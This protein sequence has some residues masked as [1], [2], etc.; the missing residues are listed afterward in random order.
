MS[1]D[2]ARLVDEAPKDT[3]YGRSPF[4]RDRARVLHS[5]AFRRLAAK[6]Q[7]HTAGTND[8]LRTR[9]THSLE[10]AQI[11][12]EMGARLGCDPDVVDTAGLAHDLGHPP[13]GHNGEYALDELAAACGGFEGN[14]QTLR[15]LTRLEA[16]VFAPDGRSAGLN[17][18]R[19]ALDA[20]S[21]YPWPRRPGERKFGVYA[22]DR[23]VFD[24]LREGAPP[25]ARRCLEAQVMDWADDVAYSVH[26]VEDGIHGGYVDLRP[27]LA[28]AD[29]RR[30]LCADVAAEYSGEAPEDLGE[31]L[32]DL[33]ADPVLAPLAAYDGS[34]RA[35]AALKATTSVLTGRFVAGV[36]AAT[37]QRHGPG[38]HRRYAADL[39]VPRRIRAQCALLKGIALRYVMRRPGAEDRYARQR[40][41]LA[42]LVA[43]LL[44]RAPDALDPVFA[45]LWRDAADDVAR[46][47]VVID[48]VASLTDPAA[49]AW[50]ARL[51]SS[52]RPGHPGGG[53]ENLG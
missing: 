11:A 15:E 46:L 50:H 49:L 44:D 37:E 9:L 8:F 3:G 6:T 51:V 47:R 10:V 4:E 34:H 5:A 32:A 20:V 41:V 30:A 1:G 39:E 19:A 17:L 22:D 38:P 18:T 42:G 40:D 29:E 27:L 25:G 13:F 48:Q 28:D 16:K 14:A 24:W 26:D 35:L 53:P 45:P 7:V 23:P 33:L 36:V 52:S 12:R 21:K 2:A 31:V 43:A